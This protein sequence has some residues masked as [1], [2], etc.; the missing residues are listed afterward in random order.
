MDTQPVSICALLALAMTGARS[1]HG[2]EEAMGAYARGHFGEAEALLLT[3]GHAGHANAQELLGFLYAI[4]PDLYPG[5]WRRLNAAGNW[6]DRAA[7]PGRTAAQYM[8][9]PFT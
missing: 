3:A 2:L 8:Q 1:A 9:A 5:V 4:G 7:P 6:F